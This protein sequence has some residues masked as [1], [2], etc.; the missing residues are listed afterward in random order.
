MNIVRKYKIHQI[1]PCLNKQEKLI[2]QDICN[3]IEGLSIYIMMSKF[4]ISYSTP[5]GNS[6]FKYFPETQLLEINSLYYL[7]IAYLNPNK[8][9]DII[10]LMCLLFEKYFNKKVKTIHVIDKFYEIFEIDL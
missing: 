9:T 2:I 6:L 1:L 10:K 4:W 7:Q 5:C 8:C 3:T